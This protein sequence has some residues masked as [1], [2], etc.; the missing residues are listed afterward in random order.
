MAERRR[1]QRVRAGSRDTDASQLSLLGSVHVQP[2]PLIRQ[3]ARAKRMSI[4]IFPQGKVEV[5]VPPRTPPAQVEQF[6]SM[7]RDWL[8]RM[9]KELQV[10]TQAELQALPERVALPAIGGEWEV[11][12]RPGQG[13]R[14]GATERAGVLRVRANPREFSTCHEVLRRWL[15]RQ[16]RRHLEPWLAR[17]SGETGLVYRRTQI[18]AQRTRWGSYS[19]HGTISLNYCLL[20]LAPELV[21]YL[22]IHELCHTRRLDHSPRYWKLVARHEPDYQELDRR[23]GAAWRD[24]PPWVL[25]S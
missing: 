19:S 17:L 11:E 24:V 13:Q 22:L 20:F 2:G 15:A 14:N 8:E 12:Y 1:T 6:V 7:N 4:K 10:P 9:V 3:S 18:R 16:G 21:R 23:L 25:P 5:V